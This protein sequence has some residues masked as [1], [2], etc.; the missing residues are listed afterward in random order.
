MFGSE[1][2]DIFEVVDAYSKALT[3]LRSRTLG[4]ALGLAGREL[5]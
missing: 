1:I 2:R 3:R 5:G 4:T